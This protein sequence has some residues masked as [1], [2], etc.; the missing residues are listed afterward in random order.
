MKKMIEYINK[1]VCEHG[2]ISIHLGTLTDKEV[3]QLEKHFSVRKG[4]MGYYSFTPKKK[5]A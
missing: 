4:F 1:K 2:N 5:S 3:S